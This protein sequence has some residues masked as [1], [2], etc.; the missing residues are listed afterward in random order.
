MY[1]GGVGQAGGQE[2]ADDGAHEDGQG[3]AGGVEAHHFRVGI[4]D[5]QIGDDGSDAGGEEHSIHIG[6][7]LFL[8][9]DAVKHYTED[10]GPN[11]Q[12]VD[13][14]G[15]E[16]N[17]QDEGQGGGI[18]GLAVKEDE[19][20]KTCG[21]NQSHIHKGGSVT[22]HGEIVAGQLAG[23]GQDCRKTFEKPVKVRH[24]D[25]SHKETEG[26]ASKKQLQK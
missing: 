14:P 26:Q 4:A 16:A 3:D 11:V 17:R 12:N 25:G 23:Q 20:A 8:L 19:Q 1:L 18:V 9:D 21:A 22:A 10:A 5:H 6:A 24:E 13:A 15:A 7:E 2:E